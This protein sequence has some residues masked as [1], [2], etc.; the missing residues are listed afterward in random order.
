MPGYK[1]G[2][3]EDGGDV[4][5]ALDCAASEFYVTVFTTTQNLKAKRSKTY[6]EEQAAY[7]AEL[8]SK[9]PD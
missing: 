7:L 8:I 4:S 3:A 9:F 1:P 2:R 5:I 6:R